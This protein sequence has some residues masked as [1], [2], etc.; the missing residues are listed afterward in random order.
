M[1]ESPGVQKAS[2]DAVA[3]VGEAEGDAA[4]VFESAVDGLGGPV[5]EKRVVEVGRGVLQ[6]ALERAPLPMNDVRTSQ[7]GWVA[8]QI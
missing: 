3:E 2:S 1:S 5:A 8:R 7:S 4:Q 6:A